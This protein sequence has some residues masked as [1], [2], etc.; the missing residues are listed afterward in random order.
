MLLCGIFPLKRPEVSIPLMF[1]L[2][3]ETW[4]LGCHRHFAKGLFLSTYM[5]L[6]ILEDLVHVAL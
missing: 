3:T 6:F 4:E 1:S 5:C 2:A